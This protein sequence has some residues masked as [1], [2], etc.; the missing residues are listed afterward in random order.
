MLKDIRRRLRPG[1][2]FVVAHLSMPTEYSIQAEWVA[3]YAAFGTKDGVEVKPEAFNAALRQ[4]RLHVVSPEE[5]EAA[6][7]EAGFSK[8]S[9]FYV[10]FAFRGWVGYA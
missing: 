4:G 1:A 7:R 3:R 8:V 2:A 6:L 5:D 9:L 10:G